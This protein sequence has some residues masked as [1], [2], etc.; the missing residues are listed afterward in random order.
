MSTVVAER[1]PEV[2]PGVSWKLPIVFGVVSV[3]ALLLFGLRGEGGTSTFRLASD[4]D[5]VALP[6]S[7]AIAVGSPTSNH[8]PVCDTPNRRSSSMARCQSCIVPNGPA[9]ASR[10]RR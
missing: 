5:V 2:R 1:A 3:L 7:G 9:G 8:S 10:S 6:E 4:G